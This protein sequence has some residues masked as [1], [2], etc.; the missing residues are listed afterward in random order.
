MAA[1]FAKF[2]HDE[3]SLYIEMR[4][5]IQSAYYKPGP[6][7]WDAELMRWGTRL[8]EFRVK[9]LEIRNSIQRTAV[10]S[11]V[12]ARRGYTVIEEVPAAPKPPKKQ[13]NKSLKIAAKRAA[14][15]N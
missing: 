6:F 4:G 3:V 9:E 15:G 1:D 13:S 12:S 2:A 5:L 14:R 8:L 7:K 10:Q 11:A